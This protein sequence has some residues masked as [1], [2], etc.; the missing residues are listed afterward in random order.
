M[1]LSY[2]IVP[3]NI[4]WQIGNWDHWWSP[5]LPVNVQPIQ[6]SRV[7][8]A[9]EEGSLARIVVYRILLG[10]LRLQ[11]YSLINMYSYCIWLSRWLGTPEVYPVPRRTRKEGNSMCGKE[12]PTHLWNNGQYLG[13]F[14]TQQFRFS[15]LRLV[16]MCLP[17]NLFLMITETADTTTLKYPWH[18]LHL[19]FNF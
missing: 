6:H 16:S 5:N 10:Q 15:H 17:Y 3:P 7:W 11:L 9:Q 14:N 12:I 1:P 19:T 18:T 13:W 2:S 8:E 4:L